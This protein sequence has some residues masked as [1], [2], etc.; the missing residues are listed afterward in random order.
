MNVKPKRCPFCA[1]KVVNVV[2]RASTKANGMLPDDGHDA[3]VLCEHCK[4]RG[5]TEWALDRDGAE[6]EAVKAWNG[7]RSRPPKPARRRV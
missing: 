5:P 1:S 2:M 7:R 3:H 4:A 6:R